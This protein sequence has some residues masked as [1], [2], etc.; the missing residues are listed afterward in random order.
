MAF[1]QTVIN[2]VKPG[3]RG[4]AEQKSQSQALVSVHS[5]GRPVWTPRDYEALAREGFAKNAIAYRCIR[6]VAEAAASIPL[7]VRINKRRDDQHP[8][9]QLLAR[10]NP[11][12]GGR[13]YFEAAYGFLQTAGNAYLEYS[14]LGDGHGELYVLRPDRMKVIPGAQGWPQ[15]YEY[16]VG[17]RSIKLTR[18]GD[19]FLPVLHLKLF[20]PA[21]DHYGFSPLEAAAFAID[22]HNA[23][24]AWNK[25]LLDNAARP[26]GALVYS[27]REGAE[28]LTAEQFD[29]LKSE[30]QDAHTG[31]QN[32]GRPV[33]L[34]GG[35]DWKPMSM[36][37]SDMD[38]MQAKNSAAREIALAFGVPP[39]LLGIPGDNT[40]ANFREAQVAFWRQTAV[41]LAEKTARMLTAWLGTRFSG[42]S[43]HCDLDEVT[44]LS[45]EREALWARLAA[46]TFL[47]DEERRRMAGLDAGDGAS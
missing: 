25:A 32:A 29:R 2:R 46:A 33:L 12:Q 45:A 26:S 16:S 17:G 6:M 18:D 21:H 36:S 34:D 22:I 24:G 9:A 28:H 8:V 39:M 7:E 20:H 15:G 14:D 5:V 43:V 11:E 3:G 27:G 41:P 44:A 13:D 1:W 19:G 40:Y 10:P 47:S 35:L 37:P 42:L 31:P 23:S 38:F 30:L 4:L